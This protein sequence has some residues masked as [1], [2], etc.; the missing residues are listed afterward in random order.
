M[1]NAYRLSFLVLTCLWQVAWSQT[2]QGFVKSLGRP[3]QKGQALS[4]VTIRVKGG[5]NA[6][7]SKT[8]GKFGLQIQ[9]EAYTLQQVQKLGYDLRDADMIGRQYA[10]S[11]TVPLT[12]VMMSKQQFEEE[13]RKI[14]DKNYAAAERQYKKRIATLERMLANKKI[15]ESQL[16][17]RKKWLQEHFDK[18]QGMI[19]GLADYYAR[20]DYDELNEVERN[21][22][23]CIE[24]GLLERA[25]SLIKS[26]GFLEKVNQTLE[27][28]AKSDELFAK[29]QQED[30]STR[31]DQDRS[32]HYFFQL[33]T[34]ELGR[35]N[36][37]KAQDYIE[38]RADLDTTN[39]QWQIDAGKFFCEYLSD[40]N[41][42][43][44]YFQR[45]LREAQNNGASQSDL[46]EAYEA[47]GNVNGLMGNLSLWNEY[48]QKS[49]S[50]NE[51]IFGNQHIKYAEGCVTMGTY[52]LAVNRFKEAL[53]QFQIALQILEHNYGKNH[54]HVA[55]CL[56]HIGNTYLT[57]SKP[58]EAYN[59][60]KEALDIRRIILPAMSPSIARS[61]NH[62]AAT[63]IAQG[64][65]RA[66][67]LHLA[68]ALGIYQKCYGEPHH[69]IALLYHTYGQTYLMI[70]DNDKA[71]EYFK[72]A[73]EG[74]VAIFGIKHT[75]VATVYLG[76]GQVFYNK[77][78]YNSAM[79]HYK[80]A[81]DIQ[82]ET[83]G[84]E[85]PN[86]GKT[87][88]S[89]GAVAYMQDDYK[90]A[91][92]CYRKAL[93]IYK[94]VYGPKHPL[95]KNVHKSISS[96]KMANGVNKL[97]KFL[98]LLGPADDKKQK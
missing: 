53:Q 61:Q 65:P 31:I 50:M 57:M 26:T 44:K 39:V 47:V 29:V 93:D 77:A 76:I 55:L 79:A 83:I 45:S 74:Y 89:I 95:V 70:N 14:E 98:N 56:A 96:I 58:K 51:C 1:T 12:I 40:Y 25:D 67:Q 46:A 81:L 16:R 87:W 4:G 43:L 21:I 82:L 17:S 24:N 20:T 30:E 91:L 19:E 59:Y 73:L 35:F 86:V 63:Y 36:N 64:A 66:A 48:A 75:D 90:K 62:I 8:D 49:L 69:A 42:G 41:K 94:K 68:M 9:G 97:N 72:K 27:M 52:Y 88:E 71:L 54:E 7:L 3:N 38:K 34:I 32:A 33:Y 85:H 18:Y 37:K 23:L 80:Y 92:E 15:K 10:F 28:K 22:N 2:Q 78:E 11:R 5:H 13:K 84:A 60:Y 6:V